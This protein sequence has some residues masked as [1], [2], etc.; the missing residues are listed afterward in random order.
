MVYQHTEYVKSVGGTK[1]QDLHLKE[2]IMIALDV[3][4]GYHSIPI[5][6]LVKLLT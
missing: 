4:R 1:K 5:K 2:L 6:H 3:L